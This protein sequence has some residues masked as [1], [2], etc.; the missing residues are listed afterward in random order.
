MKTSFNELNL[1]YIFFQLSKNKI[2]II[3]STLLIFIIILVFGFYYIQRNIQNLNKVA[4][5]VKLPYFSYQKIEIV[6]KK[7][8]GN[9]N[10]DTGNIFFTQADF[11]DQFVQYIEYPKNFS[12][13]I[14]LEQKK[15]N[16][17]FKDL[18]EAEEFTN[19]NFKYL[20]SRDGDR[21]FL[22]YPPAIDGPK[23]L[24]DYYNFVTLNLTNRFVTEVLDRALVIQVNLINNLEIAK[25]LNIIFPLLETSLKK[26]DSYREGTVVLLSKIENNQKIIDSIKNYNFQIN[27]QVSIN[28]VVQNLPITKPQLIFLSFLLSLSISLFIYLIIIFLRY[29]K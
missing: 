12:E 21:I 9:I 4:A 25:K 28:Q 1:K 14:Y 13:Y 26:D 6:K 15:Y 27:D 18:L 10:L 11:F 8:T 22:N 2:R 20:K 17:K 5:Y 24:N 16:L 7:F 29:K 23:L 19:N 3:F